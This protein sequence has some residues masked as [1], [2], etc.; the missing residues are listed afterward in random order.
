M[1]F[2]GKSIFSV[3]DDVAV[4]GRLGNCVFLHITA[5]SCTLLSPLKMVFGWHVCSV[6]TVLPIGRYVYRIGMSVRLSAQWHIKFCVAQAYVH[7]FFTKV[8]FLMVKLCLF[9]L[10]R[11][12]FFIV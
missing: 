3:D 2:N 4:V 11:L 12:R 1:C 10:L 5:H 8:K 9:L 7:T 6:I